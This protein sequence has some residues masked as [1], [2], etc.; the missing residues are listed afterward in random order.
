MKELGDLDQRRG[1]EMRGRVFRCYPKFT[2]H[3][4]ESISFPLKGPSRK[5]QHQGSKPFKMSILSL[6][7]ISCLVDLKEGFDLS[8][9]DGFY[10]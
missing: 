5:G 9:R 3:K 10:K 7:R 8:Q 2:H 4:G 1:H 6:E